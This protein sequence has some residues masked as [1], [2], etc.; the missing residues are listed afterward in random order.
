[1]GLSC[2]SSLDSLFLLQPTYFIHLLC[3]MNLIKLARWLSW[4]FF[5]GREKTSLKVSCPV[6]V[7]STANHLYHVYWR[8][9][10][11]LGKTKAFYSSLLLLPAIE[12]YE[13][14]KNF[15]I[16]GNYVCF[17]SHNYSYDYIF[18]LSY[19]GRLIS[20]PSAIGL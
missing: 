20:K 18:Y 4:R 6:T 9:M 19:L 12:S 11:L 10:S 2:W 1:M 16:S 8:R 3:F 7:R 13:F 17:T 14:S 5:E 15:V